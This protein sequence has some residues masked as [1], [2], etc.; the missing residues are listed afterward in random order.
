MA[1]IYNIVFLLLFIKSISCAE[2]MMPSFHELKT[3]ILSENNA[4][5]IALN[6]IEPSSAANLYFLLAKHGNTTITTSFFKNKKLPHV[7]YDKQTEILERLLFSGNFPMLENFF[8]KNIIS[9]VVVTQSMIEYAEA[10]SNKKMIYFLNQ[11]LKSKRSK[12]KHYDLDIDSDNDSQVKRKRYDDCSVCL[13]SLK[14]SSELKK[15]CDLNHFIHN[16][17]YQLSIH[18]GLEKCTI[19]RKPF[20]LP[21]NEQLILEQGLRRKR[22]EEEAQAVQDLLN[23]LPVAERALNL[24]GYQRRTQFWANS[25]YDEDEFPESPE[26]LFEDI[27]EDEDE[28]A[29]DDDYL[30]LDDGN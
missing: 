23:S 14:P 17:C 13:E 12:H 29:I 7:T 5:A 19:C 22:E 16:S 18:K 9:E 10:Y 28:V 26:P 8:K 27:P 20:L 1:R 25:R 15:M 30:D 24:Q 11:I 6:P 3:I 4:K 21:D 2:K